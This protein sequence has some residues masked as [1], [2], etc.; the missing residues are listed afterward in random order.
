MF[1][2]EPRSALCSA[3]VPVTVVRDVVPADR[4]VSSPPGAE[5]L[6][7]FRDMHFGNCCRRLIVLTRVMCATLQADVIAASGRPRGG[8]FRSHV[9][10]L[11]VVVM[12]VRNSPE[13]R[14]VL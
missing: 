9:A 2:A 11:S 6:G 3:G 7:P 13:I 10:H 8:L 1:G 14:S 5:L 4:S 12:S